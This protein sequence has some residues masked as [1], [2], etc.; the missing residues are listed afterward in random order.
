MGSKILNENV[1]NVLFVDKQMQISKENITSGFK[2]AANLLN[3]VILM[4]IHFFSWELIFRA[5]HLHHDVFICPVDLTVACTKTR[6]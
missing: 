4:F 1:I 3:S 5:F 2:M 6:A